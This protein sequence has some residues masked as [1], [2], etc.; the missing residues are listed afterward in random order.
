M[1]QQLVMEY[2]SFLSSNSSHSSEEFEMEDC[3]NNLVSG[4][5]VLVEETAGGVP[6]FVEEGDVE[7][8]SMHT[9][10]Y[11]D[12]AAGV[13]QHEATARI[14]N[15]PFND[16]GLF[17]RISDT[18]P[19]VV[20]VKEEVIH[21]DDFPPSNYSL[22]QSELISPSELF[23]IEE[24][25]ARYEANIATWEHIEFLKEEE[26]K[27]LGDVAL[28]QVNPTSETSS[29][30]DLTPLQEYQFKLINDSYRLRKEEKENQVMEA[31]FLAQ[32]ELSVTQCTGYGARQGHFVVNRVIEGLLPKINS[33][34]L[35]QNWLFNKENI[36]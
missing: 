18:G 35:T 8:V 19:A 12:F 28:P 6:E 5:D 27:R 33:I 29:S 24:S 2:S 7:N 36:F 11:E 14:V 4:G 9:V 15:V 17:D 20:M 1:A 22:A 21:D 30:L 25:N 34:Q 13:A 26:V 16:S 3:S 31:L 32:Q 23:R 10:D